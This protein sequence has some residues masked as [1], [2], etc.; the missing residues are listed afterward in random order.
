M[1][2]QIKKNINQ[3]KSFKLHEENRLILKSLTY[4]NFLKKL[5]RWKMQW[6]FNKFPKNS[7]LTRIKN[8]CIVTGR[9]RGF[10]RNF[11]LS[12]IQFK[13]FAS[14]KLLFNVKKK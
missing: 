7:S 13:R 8:I 14:E 3:R 4:N 1:K 6:L 11:K 2:K 10:L 5:T 12:R 9:S